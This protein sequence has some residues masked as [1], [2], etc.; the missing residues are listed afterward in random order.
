M[1]G[2]EYA[3]MGPVTITGERAEMATGYI[4]VIPT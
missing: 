3:L 1:R 4:E 2:D